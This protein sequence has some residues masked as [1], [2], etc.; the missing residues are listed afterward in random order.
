MSKIIKLVVKRNISTVRMS[1]FSSLRPLRVYGPLNTRHSVSAEEGVHGLT[2]TIY[3]HLADGNI[4]AMTIVKHGD[5][6]SAD[7]Y[8]SLGNIK[9]GTTKKGKVTMKFD[10][11]EQYHYKEPKGSPLRTYW[12]EFV[13][14]NGGEKTVGKMSGGVRLKTFWKWYKETHADDDY[15]ERESAAYDRREAY[16][17]MKTNAKIKKE[18]AEKEKEEKEM[19]KEEKIKANIRE[20]A[21]KKVKSSYVRP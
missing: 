5:G 17:A 11:K 9:K 12:Y 4:L 2:E 13:E 6:S 3:Y 21:S 8:E 19:E 20:K 1:E 16:K 18:K 15:Q 14:A 10:A 7:I